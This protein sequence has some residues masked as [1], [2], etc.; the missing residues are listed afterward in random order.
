MSSIAAE[1]GVTHATVSNVLRNNLKVRIKQQT[2]TTILQEAIRSGFHSRPDQRIDAHKRQIAFIFLDTDFAYQGFSLYHALL[3]ELKI[4]EETYR[5]NIQPYGCERDDLDKTLYKAVCED[6][7]DA[8]LLSR[9]GGPEHIN[10]LVA[11]L[12]VPLIYLE[13]LKGLHCSSIGAKSDDIGKLAAEHLHLFGYRYFASFGIKRT[14]TQERQKGFLQTLRALDIER[15]RIIELED[16]LTVI[17]GTTM[18]KALISQKINEPI[19]IFCHSNLIAH[20]VLQACYDQKISVNSRFGIVAGDDNEFCTY[21][22]PTLTALNL[23]PAQHAETL[24]EM[25]KRTF[26]GGGKETHAITPSLIQRQSTKP[27]KSY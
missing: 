9:Y 18:T 11:R 12:P 3:Q 16:E 19:G 14:Y 24:L 7:A 25:L 26:N 27:L 23:N 4:R 20:G 22:H 13:D 15:D 21:S 1:C 6:K 5:Y 17:G 10:S 8:V 2:R